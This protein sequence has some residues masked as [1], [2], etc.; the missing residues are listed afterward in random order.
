VAPEPRPPY[1]L[2]NATQA[3][4]GARRQIR[5]A[6]DTTSSGG[7]PGAVAAA[8]VTADTGA[9]GRPSCDSGTSW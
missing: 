6:V 5:R 4:P 8:A 1:R 7:D 2:V 9:A 3:A